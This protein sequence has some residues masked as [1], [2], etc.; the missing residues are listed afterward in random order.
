ML[1][2]DDRPLAER[3]RVDG[4]SPD[5]TGS[6]VVHGRRVA[7]P[8]GWPGD[9]VEEVGGAFRVVVPSPARLAPLCEWSDRCGGCDLDGLDGA[10][11]ADALQGMVAR[12]FRDEVPTRW[13]PSP[14]P[15]E[16]RARITLSR[17]GSRL[18]FHG[19]RS[20][21]LA[22]VTSCIA[23][24]PEVDAALRALRPLASSW[25]DGESQIEV[26][27]D[28]HRV[29]LRVDGDPVPVPAASVAWAG[30]VDRV[31]RR[32]D[33]AQGDATM[34]WGPT[35]FTQVH[36]ELNA[37]LVA[38]VVAWLDGCE[39]ALDLYAGI[40]NFSVPLARRGIRV[41]AVERPGPSAEALRAN[42]AGLPLSVLALDAERFDPSRVPFD[43]LVI[44][45]PRKGAGDVLRRALRNRPRR[46]VA[47]A[48]H[49]ASGARD[50]AIAVA[51]GY[52]A[53]ARTL[54]DFFPGTHHVETVTWFERTERRVTASRPTPP[55]GQGGRGGGPRRR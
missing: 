44:D 43:A 50:A 17:Q 31:G 53:V 1:E 35:A 51:E 16:T 14:Q 27:S 7:V 10:V 5:G 3:G 22:E 38:D 52:R 21:E 36:L 26:R 54:Y 4:L 47:I 55:R 19:R 40:G 8:A 2:S 12:A 24:R 15:R 41:T 23:A 30:V 42:A 6:A 49:P 32:G 37:Q 46:V 48:C 28:G 13:V 33:V 9:E 20:H 34:A 39:A 45:P 25:G 18:G 11:R 29:V